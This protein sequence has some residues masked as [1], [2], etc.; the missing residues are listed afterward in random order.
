M[1]KL[2]HIIVKNLGRN[3]LRTA[4]TAGAVAM[5]V[6]IYTMVSTV[7]TMISEAVSSHS[8]E[9]RLLV[10]GK[11]VANDGIPRRLL[12]VF[13]DVPGV[14]DWTPWS[15]YGGALDGTGRASKS[16]VGIATRK[17]NLR[18]MHPSIEGIDP[19]AIRAFKEERTAALVGDKLMKN[20]GWRVGQQFRFAEGKGRF[21]VD[22]A[23][24]IV[25]VLPPGEYDGHFFFRDD[26]F[27]EATPARDR[28]RL[29][30][31]RVSSPAVGNRV[32]AEVE[33]LC[34]KTESPVRI[35]TESATASRML[36]QNQT[37]VNVI[38]GVAMIL[39][40]DMAIVLSNSINM[41]TQERKVEMAVLRVLGFLPWHVAVLVAGEAVLVGSLAGLL[42]AAITYGYSEL[43]QMPGWP[44]PMQFLL[45]LPIR[46][47][48]VPWGFAYGAL[49][50]FFGSLLPA[51]NSRRI[52][53]TD[54]FT[55]VT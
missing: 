11:W 42:G 7:T 46:A 38:N 20:M 40:V 51:I 24:R 5:L 17:D 35:E 12:R 28:I 3:R 25:G 4:L 26:Y 10:R 55:Q 47:S 31:L 27:C 50:G 8:S 54:A 9:T 33:R 15:F 16:A 34:A 6:M 39:L 23:F 43:N 13:Q 37:I 21:G 52:K 22:L 44:W 1:H 30:W 45:D 41:A 14:E 32:A 2:I 36:G 29:A 18:S 19:A 53:V 49:I 48:A